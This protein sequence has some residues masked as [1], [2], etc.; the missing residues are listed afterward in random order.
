MINCPSLPNG[1][2]TTTLLDMA[3]AGVYGRLTSMI[4]SRHQLIRD[5][6]KVR[7]ARDHTLKIGEGLSDHDAPRMQ[8]KLPDGVFMA[9][10][11]LLDYR[12]CFSNFA[13][14]LKVTKQQ[15]I[16]RQVAEVDWG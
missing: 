2:C 11:A 13:G 3:A 5:T 9:G 6:N 4:F 16:I 14:R 7:Y 10:G 1:A 12:Y 8:M 15:H